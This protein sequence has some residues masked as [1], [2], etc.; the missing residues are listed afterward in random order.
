MKIDWSNKAEVL[1]QV[2]K[3]DSKPKL[4][5][6]ETKAHNIIIGTVL[7]GLVLGLIFALIL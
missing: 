1:A 5:K 3:N 7:G 4:H 6:P 2:K